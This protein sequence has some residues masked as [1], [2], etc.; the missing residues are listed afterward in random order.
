MHRHSLT[1]LVLALVALAIPAAAQPSAQTELVAASYLIAFGRPALPAELADAGHA[2]KDLPALIAAHRA[3][4][5]GDAALQREVDARARRDARGGAATDK[6]AAPRGAGVTY[7]DRLAEEVAALATDS[8]AY[9]AVID[10]AYQ[11]VIGRSVYPEEIEYWK[12]HGTLPYVVLVGA[13]ENWAVRNQPGL[14]VTDGTPSISVVSRF[15]ITQRLS[16]AAANQAREL[17]GLR[18][19]TDVAR[20]HSPGRNIVSRHAAEIDSVGGVHFLFAGGGP[21]AGR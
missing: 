7:A 5:Q 9:H 20:Q 10:R 8:A 18:V 14:M 4:L 19:W 16:P 17:L 11:M 13:I 12:P 3:R 2:D 15:L 6:P 1:G 21:L